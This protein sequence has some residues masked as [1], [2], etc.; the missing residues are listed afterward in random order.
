MRMNVQFF[1]MCQSGEQYI[2][3]LRLLF[4]AFVNSAEC[5]RAF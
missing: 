5:R 2:A 4:D 1:T 3:E